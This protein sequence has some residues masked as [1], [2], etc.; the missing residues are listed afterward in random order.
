MATLMA[1]RNCYGL[2]VGTRL[3]IQSSWQ[4]CCLTFSCTGPYLSFH[5]SRLSSPR[6]LYFRTCSTLTRRLAA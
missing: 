1:L 2:K 6:Y 4:H 3:S 5:S